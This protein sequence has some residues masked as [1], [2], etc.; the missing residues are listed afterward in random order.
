MLKNNQ[1]LKYFVKSGPFSGMIN[2]K[3]MEKQGKSM[4]TEDIRN[5]FFDIGQSICI[6]YSGLWF[7]KINTFLMHII[8]QKEQKHGNMPLS[9]YNRWSY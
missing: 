1:E 4:Q 7:E 6:H 8:G 5:H 3:N 9:K 2:V